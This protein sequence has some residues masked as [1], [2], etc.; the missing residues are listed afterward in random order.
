MIDALNTPAR[1]A[2]AMESLCLESEHSSQQAHR[3]A[4]T[5]EKANSDHHRSH[6]AVGQSGQLPTAAENRGGSV[7]SRQLVEKCSTLAAPAGWRLHRDSGGKRHPA[8]HRHH[9]TG[10]AHPQGT[11]PAIQHR[12]GM[13]GNRDCRD[14]HRAEWESFA[15]RSPQNVVLGPIS[16]VLASDRHVNYFRKKIGRHRE[17]PHELWAQKRAQSAFQTWKKERPNRRNSLLD[18]N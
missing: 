10:R 4:E 8:W 16:T 18:K 7:T 12:P 1:V 2:T 5:G 3:E 11:V 9:S 14:R 13:P 15:I 17:K 6:H